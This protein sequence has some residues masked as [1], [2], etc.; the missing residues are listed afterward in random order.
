VLKELVSEI[1]TGLT[2]E[3]DFL[4]G[5]LNKAGLLSKIGRRHVKRLMR[6]MGIEA[7][8]AVRAR[9]S[10]PGHV[11]GCSGPS[12]QAGHLQH[13]SGQ[14]VHRR[15]L[16]RRAHQQRH[17]D[18]HG[19]QG[20]LVGQ[21]LRRAAVAQCQIRGARPSVQLGGYAR[22]RYFLTQSVA[23]DPYVFVGQRRLNK[24][25]IILTTFGFWVGP[26]V[27][28]SFCDAALYILVFSRVIF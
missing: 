25:V 16:H 8:Y 26:Y 24:Y 10:E 20:G 17:C 6:R 14:P 7:L 1:C 18:Q 5:A 9:R 21:Y 19:R 27:L 15:G 2:L 11:E 22:F 28:F 13:G 3:N 4:E 12:R 23:R